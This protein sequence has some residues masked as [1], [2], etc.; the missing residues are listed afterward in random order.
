MTVN[1]PGET[2]EAW[3]HLDSTATQKTL[4]SQLLWLHSLM[5][6][7]TLTRCPSLPSMPGKE[8]NSRPRTFYPGT[9][10]LPGTSTVQLE[11]YR[12]GEPS[13]SGLPGVP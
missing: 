11:R 4:V 3:L 9:A 12:V 6:Q 1:T 8:L 13:L 7:G 2:P 5:H 10:F